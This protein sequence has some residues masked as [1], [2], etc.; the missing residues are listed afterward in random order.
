[1][2]TQLSTTA[3]FLFVILFYAINTEHV[4]DKLKYCYPSEHVCKHGDRRS[5]S[6]SKRYATCSSHNIDLYNF[7][8]LKHLLNIMTSSFWVKVP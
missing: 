5:F 8:Y 2:V 7:L 6:C 4:E 1:M 3:I